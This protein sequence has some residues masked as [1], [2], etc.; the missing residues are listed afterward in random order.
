MVPR[1]RQSALQLQSKQPLKI[2][3]DHSVVVA[4]DSGQA[5][6]QPPILPV[7]QSD[8]QLEVEAEW[9]AQMIQVL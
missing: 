7:L 9:I 8:Q 6:G 1:P 5:T 2:H 3:R 4:A